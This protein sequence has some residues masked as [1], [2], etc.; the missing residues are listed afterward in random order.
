MWADQ[1]KNLESTPQRQQESQKLVTVD[2]RTYTAVAKKNKKGANKGSDSDET[3]ESA[4]VIEL[5]PE[6]APQKK[7]WSVT[8]KKNKK[9]HKES[10]QVNNPPAK[11][12][13]TNKSKPAQPTREQGYHPFQGRGPRFKPKHQGQW[14]EPAWGHGQ[15]GEYHPRSDQRYHQGGHH[16]Y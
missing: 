4:E 13:N 2:G 5:P 9:S 11:P 7:A 12:N 1:R 10:V 6:A 14:S 15:R 16:G 3:E 8:N